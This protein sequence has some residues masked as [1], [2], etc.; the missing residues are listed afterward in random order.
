MRSRL[1]GLVLCTASMTSLGMGTAPLA[2]ASPAPPGN[3]AP[4]HHLPAGTRFYVP[5]PARGSVRQIAQLLGSHQ[6]HEAGLIAAMEAT[7]SAVWLDGETAAQASE[8]ARGEQQ[9]DFDV[10]RQV[11]TALLGARL[12]G[13]VPVF[14]AYD[15]P[16]RDCSQYSAGGAPSDAA[17]DAWIDSIKDALASSA[18]V[19]ILEPDAL[20]NLPGYCGS[21]YNA[22]FPQITDTTRIQD[23]AYGVTALE[24]D[25]NISLYLDGGH[26]AW[27]A[28]GN[29]AEVLVAADVQQAQGFFLNVSNY[30]YATNNVFYGI[31]VS[32]C[33]AYATVNEG[34]TEAQALSDAS[35]LVSS[36][37]GPSGPFSNCPN[38]YWNGGPANGYG[39]T[40][41]T[42]VAVSPY[43]VWSESQA[44]GDLSTAGTDSWYPN[45]LGA[46]VPST[47][48]VIDTSRDG[49]GP[50]DMEAYYNAPY[51]QPQSVVGSTPGAQYPDNSPPGGSLQNGNWCNPPSSGL[52]ITPT[53]D[54]STV[55]NSLDSYLPA[56]TP[57][58]DA[59]LWVKTPGQSDGQCDVAG[60]VRNWDDSAGTVEAT[61]PG[62]PASGTSTFTTFD[63]LWSIETSSVFTD[64]AAGAWFPEQA[65]QLAEDANPP[66]SPLFPPTPHSAPSSR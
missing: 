2:A 46:T 66:L 44:N 20:A 4:G 45:Y 55:A 27:Q 56:G 65:L 34:V 6:P 13:A 17:Y 14:V 32:S 37:N 15:I 29:I 22:E 18:A 16:G 39:S 8:G 54:T 49:Q 9:A 38:Q 53:A 3:L 63:P 30:Q 31:W 35:T 47:H 10:A 12:E 41:G 57:L 60:G 42:G 23:I 64:P 48:F 62:W 51:D 36:N 21:A 40:P 19:V 50:N 24:G 58:L 59:Y 7:P 61:I 25:P 1:I 33:I 26:S 43:G 28:V 11:R 52:G 5:P